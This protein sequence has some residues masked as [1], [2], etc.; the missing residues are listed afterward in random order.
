MISLQN[1]ETV[2]LYNPDILKKINF[3]KYEKKFNPAVSIVNPGPGLVIRPLCSSD[4]KCG[5]LWDLNLEYK[6]IWIKYFLIPMLT[7]LDI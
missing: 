2:Q 5:K 1:G 6:I 4:Y 3:S 7:Y